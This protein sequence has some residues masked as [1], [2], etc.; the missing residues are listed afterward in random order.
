MFPRLYKETLSGRETLFPQEVATSNAYL[1]LQQGDFVQALAL[2]TGED[3]RSYY[4]RGVI[5][6]ITAY[7]QAS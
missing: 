1:L 3:S 5:K 4:N 6:T 7:D 2:I